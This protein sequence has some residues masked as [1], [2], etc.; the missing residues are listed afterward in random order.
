M[1]RP[2]GWWTVL[3]LVLL[4]PLL[5]PPA[6][7]CDVPHNSSRRP[8]LLAHAMPSYRFRLPNG[9]RVACPDAAWPGC[10]PA[11]TPQQP[12][13]VCKGLG[14]AG[15]AG[16][17]MPLN[18]FGRDFIAAGAAWTLPLCLADSDGDG[19]TNGQELG[20]PCCAWVQREAELGVL[21]PTFAAALAAHN[22]SHPGVANGDASAAEVIR[23][24]DASSGGVLTDEYDDDPDKST[25]AKF[26]LEGEDMHTADFY[27]DDFHV[28]EQ[29]RTTYVWFGWTFDAPECRE[30]GKSC[31]LVGADAIIDNAPYVHHFVVTTSPFQVGAQ[32]F[33]GDGLRDGG[34]CGGLSAGVQYLAGWAPGGNPM[35]KAPPQAS[36]LITEKVASICM[37]VHYTNDYYVKDVR[38]SSGIRLHY[39]TTP[40]EHLLGT[41]SV[42]QLSY[43]KHTVIPPHQ[44]RFFVTRG[45]TVE[46]ATQPLRVA[47][48][49]FHAH[50]L[51]REMYASR[52]EAD[53]VVTSLWDEPTWYFDDQYAKSLLASG[54]ELHQ[55]DH[56]QGTCVYNSSER[57]SGTIIGIETIDEMCWVQ[58]HYFPAQAVECEG[59][60]WLGKLEKN[61]DA[62]QIP[63]TH[64]LPA[65]Q[66][67]SSISTQNKC[68][69]EMIH[70][71]VKDDM[72]TRYP[73]SV[74]SRD[75]QNERCRRLVDMLEACILQVATNTTSLDQHAI[76]KINAITPEFNKVF[77]ANKDTI[78]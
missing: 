10:T 66:H 17:A 33:I 70:L 72:T 11:E 47:S 14:H 18:P 3:P 46:G 37:Q 19:M 22:A 9:D 28:P 8:L 36:M 15:C 77:F 38:D 58:V 45:C 68:D 55:G 23:C 76:S 34:P 63:F 39:T 60:T 1:H 49:F 4:L 44:E 25:A 75:V 51:G 61:E 50:L 24:A 26:F 2:F 12:S 41:L 56:L 59:S 29:N 52:I 31:Y 40:R 21:D 71:I 67:G 43:D 27:I 13:L 53:T 78:N 64:P 35:F 48:V 65:G 54:T 6:P 30:D 7:P 16:G 32:G 5:L 62:R 73:L 57:D 74:C 20:D 42:Q 69:G